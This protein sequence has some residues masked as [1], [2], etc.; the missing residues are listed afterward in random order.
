MM[1][2]YPLKC[3]KIGFIIQRRKRTVTDLLN[4]AP[5]CVYA[6]FDPT[7]DSLHIGNL[8]VGGATAKIGDPSGRTT[9]REELTTTFINENV[10]GIKLNIKNIFSNHEQYIWK[11]DKKLPSLKLINNED[12]YKQMSAVN[13]INGAGRYLRM[14]TL[15]SRTSVHTRLQSPVGMSFTEFSYQL[16]QAYD[17][18][19]LFQKYNCL[20][21]IGGNDQM[22]LT[23]PLITTEMGNKFGKSAGN[24][25]W[26]SHNKTS[27]F[28]L[29]QF[30]VRQ[31]DAEV[32]KMLK[33]FTFDSIGRISDLMRQHTEKPELR[34]PHKH[35]A[36][37]VVILVHG[38]KGLE[39]A[40]KAT[41]ALYEKSVSAL[42]EMN[43]NEIKNLFEGATV[44][45]ILPEPGQ[46]ILDLS[47]KAQCFPTREDAVR[48]ITAGGFYINHQR[49]NNPSE[50]LNLNV[51][52]LANNITLLRV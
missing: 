22:G 26:L 21:Q 19:H 14:G 1:G 34:L 43:T 37:Q 41:E 7:A 27:P 28:T 44:I 33:L 20:F 5:Q 35:L 45:E 29:Y 39:S 46:S 48:I 12:W 10:E 2:K 4:A 24:A 52:R 40:L 15:L 17:W 25:M 8:L 49:I 38:E 42:G 36:E 11:Q 47:M 32:E 16:F 23:V 6:G 18:L 3:N 9:E 31:T 51:H 13:L 30:F 50:I